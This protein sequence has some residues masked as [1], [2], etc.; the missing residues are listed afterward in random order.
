[1]NRAVQRYSWQ[2]LVEIH[3]DLPGAHPALEKAAGEVARLVAAQLS[4]REKALQDDPGSFNFPKNVAR[5]QAR[6]PDLSLALEGRISAALAHAHRS[7]PSLPVQVRVFM[8]EK[9][10]LAGESWGV[11]LI[12]RGSAGSHFQHTLEI[13]LYREGSPAGSGL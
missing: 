4:A 7:Q 8:D 10:R 12:E 5:S 6:P 2:I 1:M 13:F 9:P 3:L 11:F